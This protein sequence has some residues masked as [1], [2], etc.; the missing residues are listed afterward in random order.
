MLY[1]AIVAVAFV[2]LVKIVADFTREAKHLE[3]F[4]RKWPS[5]DDD[6][7]V[8]KCSPDINPK[9]ALKVRRIISQQLGIPYEHIHPGQSFGNDLDF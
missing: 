3:K 1:V 8:R 2:A 6:E 7:F 4:K 5:I 9:T